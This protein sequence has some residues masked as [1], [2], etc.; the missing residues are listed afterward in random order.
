MGTTTSVPATLDAILSTVTAALAPVKAFEQW[1]G[2]SA[3]AE[4]FVLGD[5]LWDDYDIA[6]VTAGRK[7]RQEAWSVGFDVFVFHTATSI[8]S[9]PKPARDRAFAIFGGL[10]NVCANDPRMGLPAATIQWATSRPVEAGPRV[11]EKAWAY[12]V[13]GRIHVEARLT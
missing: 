5:I 7:Q 10:E 9:N 1:P 12:R 11:F 3:A 2:P 13:A 6:T 4:M 8:P